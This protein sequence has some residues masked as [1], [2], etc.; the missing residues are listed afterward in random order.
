MRGGIQQTSIKSEPIRFRSTTLMSSSCLFPEGSVKSQQLIF[1]GHRGNFKT[2]PLQVF[3]GKLVIAPSFS[4]VLPYWHVSITLS[5]SSP[6][7]IT[8]SLCVRLSSLHLLLYHPPTHTHT[9]I[10]HR[11][12]HTHNAITQR[13][14]HTQMHYKSLCQFFFSFQKVVCKAK[15]ALRRQKLVEKITGEDK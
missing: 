4:I 5:S 2:L 8:L 1:R 11:A 12:T 10:T 9:A 7:S 13:N 3:N 6:S 14:T 15:E